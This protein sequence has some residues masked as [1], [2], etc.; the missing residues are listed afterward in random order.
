MRNITVGVIL[1][2]IISVII[3]LCLKQSSKSQKVEFINQKTGIK[4]VA[5]EDSYTIGLGVVQEDRW[6]NILT[7]HLK[8][9]R[10]N[11]QLV[12]NPAVSGYTV[13]DAIEIELTEVKKIKPDLVTVLIGAN[14]NFGQKDAETYRQDLRE[15]LDRL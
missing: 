14:D 3:V 2:V 13:E 4:Y 6:P 8:K 10:V 9:E 15:L 11:I 5:I 1:I 12:A 7:D